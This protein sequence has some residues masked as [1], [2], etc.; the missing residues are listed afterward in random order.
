MTCDGN[1]DDGD[2]FSECQ[3]DCNDGDASVI[4]LVADPTA[5]AGGDGSPAN[6]Y[7]TITAAYGGLGT[8]SCRAIALRPGTYT[9]GVAGGITGLLYRVTIAS[10]AGPATTVWR[11]AANNYAL[12]GEGPIT[13]RGITFQS[14]TGTT[15]KGVL[16]D[17]NSYACTDL[18][19][20]NCVFDKVTRPVTI[21][22]CSG[23]MAFRCNIFRNNV[24]SP[25]SSYSLAGAIMEKDSYGSHT[26]SILNNVFENNQSTGN[27]A[28]VAIYHTV[29]LIQGNR[30]L[31]NSTTQN[32][33][34]IYASNS[35]FTG[36]MRIR[37]NWF[38][39]NRA[40]S[41][42]GVF[43]TADNANVYIENNVFDANVAS[44]SGG[45]LCLHGRSGAT[46]RLANNTFVDNQAGLGGHAHLRLWVGDVFANVFAVTWGGGGLS[47]DNWTNAADAPLFSYNDTYLNTPDYTGALTTLTITGQNGNVTA[48]DPTFVNYSMDQDPLNDDLHLQ[49]SS[50]LRNA[51]PCAPPTVWDADGSC[52]DPGA[53]GGPGGNW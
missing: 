9:D 26:Y 35:G 8:R 18:T 25:D 48:I 4:P 6:P 30:F 12:R 10:M 43:L 31:N 47:A 44:G 19:I 29:G 11:P 34:A 45:G 17:A 15:S 21:V 16:F 22:E 38:G 13:L 1:D 2:G 20:E 37:Q 28:A 23:A 52:N 46:R 39:G 3:G 33:G 7:R 36:D 32:G 49:S 53:Y 5:A 27:G 24:A 41:G 50:P 42:A 14:T 40:V 51:G